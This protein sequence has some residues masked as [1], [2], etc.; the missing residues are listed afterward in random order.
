MIDRSRSDQRDHPRARSSTCASRG[1][2]KVHAARTSTPSQG[3][4][5]SDQEKSGLSIDLFARSASWTGFVTSATST[6]SF[7][8]NR[9]CEPTDIWHDAGSDALFGAFIATLQNGGPS[10][11][12]CG[13]WHRDASA[14]SSAARRLT[15]SRWST[16][17]TSSQTDGV[18]IGRAFRAR[19]AGQ[20]LARLIGLDQPFTEQ[21]MWRLAR[22]G[23][24][25]SVRLRRSVF[26]QSEALEAFVARGGAG[27]P[28]KPEGQ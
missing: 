4:A 17:M 16:I 27:V 7:L 1:N 20:Y 18:M 25:P 9:D 24:L 14:R 2:G 5:S 3:R 26:F 22:E 13:T 11:G 28:R 12:G 21:H 8:T 19:E 6:D 15:C 10:D 23:V